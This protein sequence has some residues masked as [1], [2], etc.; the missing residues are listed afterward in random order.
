MRLF[1]RLAGRKTDDLFRPRLALAVLC[2]RETA[3]EDRDHAVVDFLTREVLDL[4]LVDLRRG[5]RGALVRVEEALP[6][7]VELGGCHRGKP[8]LG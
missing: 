5:T 3:H 4:W 8:V 2:L 6:A 7:L 1:R